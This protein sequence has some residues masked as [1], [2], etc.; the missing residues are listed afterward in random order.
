MIKYLFATAL[1]LA[2][3]SSRDEAFCSC[4]EIGEEFNK[5]SQAYLEKGEGDQAELSALK[6][7][8]DKACANYTEMSGEEMLRRK[9]DCGL[10]E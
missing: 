5:A 10:E 6:T 1:L 2:A 3:C 8:K 7:E 4:L 9:K